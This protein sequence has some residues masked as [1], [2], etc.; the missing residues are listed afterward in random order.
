[1]HVPHIHRKHVKSV[2]HTHTR[3][4]GC[5]CSDWSLKSSSWADPC[6]LVQLKDVTLEVFTAPADFFFSFPP[7]LPLFTHSL[8]WRHSHITYNMS[9]EKN[10]TEK[11]PQMVLHPYSLMSQA[12][13]H[14]TAH[15]TSPSPPQRPVSLIWVS[16]V[17]SFQKAPSSSS[18]SA[19]L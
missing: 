13:L 15:P 3:R 16:E 14:R 7:F 18:F 4:C 8:F 19:P 17:D 6:K 12:K 10:C 1:M 5:L 2:N 11:Q 9:P